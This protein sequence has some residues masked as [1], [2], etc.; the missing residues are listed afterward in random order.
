VSFFRSEFICIYIIYIYQKEKRKGEKERRELIKKAAAAAAAAAEAAAAEQK[1]LMDEMLI[2]Y[3]AKAPQTAWGLLE[4]E[5]AQVFATGSFKRVYRAKWR[6]PDNLS[7]V[8]ALIRQDSKDIGGAGVDQDKR[9]VAL[10]VPTNGA[11]M[12]HEIKILEFLGPHPHIAALLATSL[13]DKT[14]PNKCMLM[15]YAGKGSLDTVLADIHEKTHGNMNLNSVLLTTAIQVAG[16][17]E[18]AGVENVC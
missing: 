1:R 3:G 14:P 17:H 18:A 4:I 6:I 7:A 9:L 5:N 8:S 16:R 10:L 12:E 15:E 13:D 2:R 11:Q